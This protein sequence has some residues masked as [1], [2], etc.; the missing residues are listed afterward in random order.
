[1][2][3]SEMYNFAV[4]DIEGHVV[5]IGWDELSKNGLF[6]IHQNE[7]NNLITDLFAINSRYY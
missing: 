5:S 6:E 7:V 3:F 2:V 4:V 1:M